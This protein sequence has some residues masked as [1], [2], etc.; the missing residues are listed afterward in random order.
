MPLAVGHLST[1]PLCIAA[2]AASR[3][4]NCSHLRVVKLSL[5]P[6]DTAA[7]QGQARQNCNRRALCGDHRWFMKRCG[8]DVSAFVL[9]VSRDLRRSWSMVCIYGPFK[10]CNSRVSTTGF[11]W[12][13][14]PF[15]GIWTFSFQWQTCIRWWAE[16]TN[17]SI[18]P[19]FESKTGDISETRRNWSIKSS[20][21]CEQLLLLSFWTGWYW[22]LNT[23]RVFGQFYH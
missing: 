5:S 18:I 9:P 7:G 8:A 14:F 1:I 16:S 6:C 15:T 4:E 17:P 12:A 3:S 20:T 22:T 10:H 19:L 23:K 2:A 13:S 11:V 21:L